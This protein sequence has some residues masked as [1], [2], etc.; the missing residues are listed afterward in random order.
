MM[1]ENVSDA[2]NV[3]EESCTNGKVVEKQLKVERVLLRI[4]KAHL[5]GFDT[6]PPPQTATSPLTKHVV[7]LL[8]VGIVQHLVRAVDLLELLGGVLAGV[9]VGMVLLGELAVGRLDLLGVGAAGDAEDLVE[10]PAGRSPSGHVEGGGEGSLGGVRSISTGM[11]D[12]R[13]AAA[14]GRRW[15]EG[16]RGRREQNGRQS[17]CLEEGEHDSLN[18]R[19]A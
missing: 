1:G 3:D 12:G 9:G 4:C 17:R 15:R 2:S 10:I 14:N 8:H 6:S 19:Y 5:S 16:L 18:V 13:S 11:A 7:L